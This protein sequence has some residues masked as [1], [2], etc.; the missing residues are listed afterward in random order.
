[1]FLG[2]LVFL[3]FSRVPD[4]LGCVGVGRPPK[5]EGALGCRSTPLSLRAIGAEL[6]FLERASGT[7]FL[8]VSFLVL[9][10][11]SGPEAIPKSTT[12]PY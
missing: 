10:P 6:L 12:A 5:L 2:L 4:L 11:G 7:V 3:C 8:L 1:M 9:S